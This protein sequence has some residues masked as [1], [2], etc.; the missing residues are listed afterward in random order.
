VNKYTRQEAIAQSKKYKRH[1]LIV[2]WTGVLLCAAYSALNFT[3]NMTGLAIAS[4]VAVLYCG[5]IISSAESYLRRFKAYASFI[6]EQ[7]VFS[8]PEI[9]A[10]TGDSK[11]V[12]KTILREFQG[13]PAL[14]GIT[15]NYEEIKQQEFI[16][17]VS[18]G[19]VGQSGQCDFCGSVLKRGDE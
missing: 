15:F 19:A 16:D 9:A 12:V 1:R 5:W 6:F 18:C 10:K 14:R 3:R 2:G 17:C 8:I 4:A 13:I 11:E 7:S